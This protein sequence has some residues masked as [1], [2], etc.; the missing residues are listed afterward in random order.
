MR[1]GTR[2]LGRVRAGAYYLLSIDTVSGYAVV[3]PVGE[4]TLAY[5]GEQFPFEVLG[6]VLG[7]VYH[8]ITA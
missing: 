8:G 5:V 2:L 1:R 4:A 7:V 6:Y 3:V